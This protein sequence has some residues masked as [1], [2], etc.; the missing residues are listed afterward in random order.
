MHQPIT[1]TTIAMMGA[2]VANGIVAG[3]SEAGVGLARSGS[4][5][6]RTPDPAWRNRSRT[7]G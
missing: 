1:N 5:L 6:S 2:P 7:N 3:Q 4:G